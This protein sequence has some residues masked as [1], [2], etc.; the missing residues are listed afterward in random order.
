MLGHSLWTVKLLAPLFY[1]LFLF[2]IIGD[3]V[4]W[5]AAIWAPL[6]LICIAIAAYVCAS[7]AM[8]FDKQH[9]HPTNSSMH[10]THR[11]EDSI[12]EIAMTDMVSSVRSIVKGEV[13]VEEVESST[14]DVVCDDGGDSE[15]VSN[16]MV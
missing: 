3:E 5:K 11:K 9:E 7:A 14:D 12:Q 4:G 16:P 2:D 13:E 1:S 6:T 8:Y 10:K 15:V